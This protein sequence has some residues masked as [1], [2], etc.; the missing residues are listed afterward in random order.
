[1]ILTAIFQSF[2]RLWISLSS[3]TGISMEEKKKQKRTRVKEADE[4]KK[5]K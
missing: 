1:L 2:L 5:L 3:L 4:E